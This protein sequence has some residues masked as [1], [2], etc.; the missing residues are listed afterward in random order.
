VADVG[1]KKL[2]SLAFGTG[3]I[4]Q[5]GLCMKKIATDRRNGEDRRSGNRV[6]KGRRAGE[7]HPNAVLTNGEV[8][9]MRQLRESGKTWDWLVDKFEVPKRTVRDICSYRRR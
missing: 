6:G 7:E 9:L 5:G 2:R 1:S 4:L 8:E 3:E